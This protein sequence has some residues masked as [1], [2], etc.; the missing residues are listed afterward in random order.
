VSDDENDRGLD[1]AALWS[2]LHSEAGTRSPAHR[3]MYALLADDVDR[4]IDALYGRPARPPIRLS[5]SEYEGTAGEP[6]R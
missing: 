6:D 3:L 4:A 5:R 2:A 1:L